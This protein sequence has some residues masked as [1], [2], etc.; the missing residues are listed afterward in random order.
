[1]AWVVTSR[2][3]STPMKTSFE[4]LAASPRLA[5]APLTD[6]R[7]SRTTMAPQADAVGV[8]NEPNSVEAL[9]LINGPESGPRQPPP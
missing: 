9:S 5:A 2:I 4:G 3:R 7:S 1:M 6:Y 8:R